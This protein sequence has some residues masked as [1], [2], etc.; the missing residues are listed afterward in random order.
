MAET[1]VVKG[2]VDLLKSMQLK[3]AALRTQ[4]PLK[5]AVGQVKAYN[6]TSF[7]VACNTVPGTAVLFF[8]PE[9]HLG[10]NNNHLNNRNMENK[11]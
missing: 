7:H 2:K 4:R 5:A 10:V 8:F 6:L 1:E 9:L 3:Q 11:E